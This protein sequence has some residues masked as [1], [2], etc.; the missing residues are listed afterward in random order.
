[1]ASQLRVTQSANAAALAAT[2][3]Y[4]FKADSHR[5]V[6]VQ[7]VWTAVTVSATATLQSSNDNTTWANF[8]TATTISASGNVM[9]NVDSVDALYWQVTY[10]HTSGASTTFKAYVANVP[11]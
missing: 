2:T 6:S 1:M 10:T 4:P 9:W 11:R 8:A 3:S 5:V 7:A